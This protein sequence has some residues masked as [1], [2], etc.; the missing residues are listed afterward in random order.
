MIFLGIFSLTTKMGV[1]FKKY[2]RIRN[3]SQNVAQI[4]KLEGNISSHASF[5]ITLYNY[6]VDG[7]QKV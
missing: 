6:D 4:S 3:E 1:D 2:K 7:P 5:A